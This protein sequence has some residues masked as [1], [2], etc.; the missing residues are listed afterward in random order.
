MWTGA[1]VLAYL[2]VVR[3]DDNSPAWW[4]VVLLAFGMV[5]LIAVVAGWLSRPALVASAVV[6]ALAALLGLLSIGIFLLPSLVCVFAAGLVME[7][8]SGTASEPR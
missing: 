5:P 7:R 2:A 3:Q 8:T 6:H 4:Y 1:Y